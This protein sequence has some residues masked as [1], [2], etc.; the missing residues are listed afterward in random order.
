M[1]MPESRITNARRYWLLAALLVFLSINA[2][3]DTLPVAD[4]QK[5][6]KRAVTALDT[7]QQI[8]ETETVYD[9]DNRLDQTIAAV[10]EALPEHEAVQAS[11]EVC[12]VDNSWLHA[13]LK[14]L[15]DAPSEQRA[16]KLTQLIERLRAVEDRVGYERRPPAS[17]S[18]DQR[19]QKLESILARP[20][21]ASE[22]RGPNALARLIEDFIRWLQQFLP[23]P[24]QVETGRASWMSIVIQVLVVIVALFVLFYVVKLLS[25]RFGGTRRRGKAKQSKVR[26]VLGEQLKPEDTATDL[27]SEAE[28][29]ARRGDLRAAIRKAYIALLV[30]LGD[31]KLIQL[32]QNKTNRDYLNSVRSIPLLHS[33]MGAM[34]DSFEQHWYG[35]VEA[36]ENDWQN[37]RSRYH[38]ALQTQN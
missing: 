22:A 3:A 37:F 25:M 12:N 11:D 6:L 38:A 34:T 7:L 26:I 18:K 23:K 8:D 28:A 10:R 19:K 1:L 29:L 30:E 27:L 35:F 9:Y 32:A 17:D 21:F 36:T 33:R 2:K 5:N 20:E 4:Y 16:T 14:D 13:A 24:V 31:R 15:K